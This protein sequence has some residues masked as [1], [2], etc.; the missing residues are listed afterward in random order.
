MITVTINALDVDEPP[1]APTG[2][3]EYTVDEDAA[4]AA[5]I[6]TGGISQCRSASS[7]MWKWKA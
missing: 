4:L 1:A 2:T 5:N 7:I 6:R 3:I